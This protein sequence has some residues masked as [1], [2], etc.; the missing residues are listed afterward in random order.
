VVKPS[1]VI[2]YIQQPTLH[3]GPITIHAFGVLVALA[4]IVGMRVVRQRATAGGLDGALADRMVT[5]ILLGGFAGAHLVDRLIYFPRETLQEPWR[6][7]KFWEGLSSFGGF[8]GAVVGAVLFFR[9]V[10]VGDK[11]W[12]YLDCVAYGFPFGWIFGRLGCSVAFDHPGRETTF[13]LSEVYTDQRV[14][15]NLGLDEAIYTVPLAALF[16]VLGRKPRRPGFFVGLLPLLYAP[17][18]FSFDFLRVIDVRY[19][20]LTPGQWGA[21]GLLLVGVVILRRKNEGEAK[22]SPS[23]A[24]G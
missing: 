24:S 2:P 10:D 12:P 16:Y 21:V 6:L 23:T 20:G 8:L 22:A 15:H 13:F 14:R 5:W 7:L 9:R 4:M 1:A 18:R 11:R 3:L 17:V 19:L